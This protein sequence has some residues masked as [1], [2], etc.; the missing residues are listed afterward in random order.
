MFHTKKR[1]LMMHMTFS[2]FQKFPNLKNPPML[3]IFT[4]ALATVST[5][6]A[7][8]KTVLPQ[9]PNTTLHQQ[10][11]T[12][13]NPVC[14]SLNS[15][16]EKKKR[17]SKNTTSQNYGLHVFATGANG[18]LFHM[19]QTSNI[20]DSGQASM[21]EWACLTPD[22][23][24]ASAGFV[25]PVWWWYVFYIYTYIYLLPLFMLFK[26]MK[27]IVAHTH[28]HTGIPPQSSIRMVISMCLFVSWLTKISG[29]YTKKIRRILNPLRLRDLRG[30]CGTS[31]L[32]TMSFLFESCVAQTNT[33]THTHK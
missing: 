20:S 9:D 30:V 32:F 19:W 2:F 8:N 13:I 33:H 3:L 7:Y 4:L 26:K 14:I 23:V 16:Y 25:P 5:T 1:R 12:V 10:F 17:R 29:S 31:F 24:Y 15:R 28:I 27:S 18:S 22:P 21:S 11:A 6:L